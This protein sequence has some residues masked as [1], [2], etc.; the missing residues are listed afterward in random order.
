MVPGSGWDKTYHKI[1]IRNHYLFDTT[2][3]VWEYTATALACPFPGVPSPSFVVRL[4]QS[5]AAIWKGESRPALLQTSRSEMIRRRTNG[6]GNSRSRIPEIG[7]HFFC[8]QRYC[9]HAFLPQLI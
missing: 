6:N 1:E 3:G 8:I 4:Q 5:G 7:E 9:Y 2:S